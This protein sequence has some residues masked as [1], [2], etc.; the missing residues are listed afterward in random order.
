MKQ[1]GIGFFER[2]KV[3]WRFVIVTNLKTYATEMATVFCG[4]HS[5]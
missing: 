3:M 2:E 1:F 5:G 4:P